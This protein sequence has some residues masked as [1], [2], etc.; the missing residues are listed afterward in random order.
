MTIDGTT[1][2]LKAAVKNGV[3][4]VVITSSWGTALDRMSIFVHIILVDNRHIPIADLKQTYAGIT[5][6]QKS[7]TIISFQ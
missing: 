7:E 4:K 6:T 5:F 2:V 3:S 1:S